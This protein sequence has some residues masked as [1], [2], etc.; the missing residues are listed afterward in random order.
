MKDAVIIGSGPGGYYCALKLAKLGK[1]VAIVEERDIGG[2]CT[3][4][5]C[6]PTKALLESARILHEARNSE[7]MGIECNVEL[8]FEKAK[9]NA[10][11]AVKRSQK[12]IEHLLT[13]ANVSILSGRGRLTERNVVEVSG[14]NDGSV[15]AEN[16]VIATGSH[17]RDLPN[18]ACDGKTIL[19]SR[20]LLNIDHIPESLLIIGGGSIGVEFAAIFSTFGSQVTVA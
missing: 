7:R 9:K 14:E 15:E 12:G 2:V 10:E 17:T 19:S 18:I 13:T 3:N 5:G 1:D 4:S 8:N 16:V 20:D 6:I 11:L